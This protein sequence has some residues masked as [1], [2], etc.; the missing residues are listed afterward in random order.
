MVQVATTRTAGLAL[1]LMLLSYGGVA[2]EEPARARPRGGQVPY[3][4]AAGL[5][6]VLYTP[7]KG[8]LCF[9]GGIGSGFAFL[10]SG[11]TAAKAVAEASCKGKWVLTPGVVRGTEPFEFVGEIDQTPGR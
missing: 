8:V 7:L 6:T 1:A 5:G 10:S 2:A 11:T 9:T 4:V 3:S